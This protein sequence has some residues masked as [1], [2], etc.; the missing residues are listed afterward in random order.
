MSFDDL[1]RSVSTLFNDLAVQPLTHF[2]H[3]L[4]NGDRTVLYVLL[5]AAVAF[6][7]LVG[8]RR[9]RGSDGNSPMEVLLHMCLG[10]RRQVKRLIALERSRSPGISRREAIARAIESLRRDNAGHR[11]PPEVN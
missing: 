10:D 3:G 1:A 2:F 8:R 11:V 9:R 4:S 6:G 5:A 7:F